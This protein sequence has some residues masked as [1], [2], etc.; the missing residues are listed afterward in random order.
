[1]SIC[2]DGTLNIAEYRNAPVRIVWL[3]KEAL[4]GGNLS[5]QLE[6]SIKETRYSPTWL[7]MAYPAY[8]VINGWKSGVFTKWEDVP[9]LDKGVLK[10]LR[11]IAVVNVKKEV[12]VAKN[13]LSKDA[14]IRNAYKENRELVNRQ[15]ADLD[16]DIIV[17]GYPN[18]LYRIV[19]DV[20][21]TQTG[22]DY[23]SDKEIGDFSMTTE[24]VNG[25][26]RL[27]LW[28]YHPSYYRSEEQGKY[29]KYKYFTTF[30]NA[31]KEFRKMQ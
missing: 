24:K 12:C 27:F 13:G 4:Y 22:K 3:L 2:N 30:I 7:T 19:N 17:F 31:V 21:K 15:I 18:A 10:I 5:D 23:R 20:F 6:H 9:S 11:Q 25:K 28:G 29:S 16:A 8:A 1:M 14:E 26:R